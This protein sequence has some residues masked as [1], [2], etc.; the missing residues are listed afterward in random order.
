MTEDRMSIAE[1]RRRLSAGE[2]PPT[3]PRNKYKAVRTIYNGVGYDSKAE[4]A[5]ARNLDLMLS[6]GE[7]YAWFRQV[8]LPLGPDDT[9]RLDFLV[10]APGP[11]VWLEDVKGRETPDFRRKLKLWQKYGQYELHIIK[12]SGTLVVPGGRMPPV[13]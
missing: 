4:A 6:A 11:T 9:W 13:T 3:K 1:W 2:T 5:R 8:K 12:S 7:I 10:F